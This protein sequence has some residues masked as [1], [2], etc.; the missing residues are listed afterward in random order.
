MQNKLTIAIAIGA[1]LCAS[2]GAANYEVKQI[3]VG[4]KKATITADK[5]ITAGDTLLL[6]NK[7]GKCS[8]EVLDVEGNTAVISIARC[9]STVE[10]ADVVIAMQDNT[11]D[12]TS[13]RYVLG[14]V[15]GTTIGLGIGH[16]VQ[17]RWQKGYGWF[18]TIAAI[19]TAVGG[20]FPMCRISQEKDIYEPAYEECAR[21]NNR[22]KRPWQIAFWAVRGLEV[23]S[24]WWP[25]AHLTFKTDQINS[26][27]MPIL[28]KKHAG[29]QL[30]V[31]F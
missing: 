20:M 18:F 9:D 19:V 23:V 10:I 6:V 30:V 3:D 7:N 21:K 31:S 12:I 22:K 5:N 13:V 29:L 1:A 17:G 28:N 14:G 16:A 26:S 27:V 24:V 2:Y 11:T 4:A 8:V 15:I 25:P